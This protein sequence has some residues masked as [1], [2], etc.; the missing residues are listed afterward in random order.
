MNGDGDAAG[1]DSF[2]A[3]WAASDRAD[4]EGCEAA[5]ARFLEIG[6]P[7]PVRLGAQEV[8]SRLPGYVPED[9]DALFH[10]GD[11]DRTRRAIRAFPRLRRFLDP[12]E[13]AR[14]HEN[15]LAAAVREEVGAD[16]TS[17]ADVKHP[18]RALAWF[19]TGFLILHGRAFGDGPE[20]W[21][22]ND[23]T[24]RD[25]FARK[26]RAEALFNLGRL[27]ERW[28]AS[29]R[30][31]WQK[32]RDAAEER[33]DALAREWREIV[34]TV[35]RH[36]GPNVGEGEALRAAADELRMPFGAVRNVWYRRRPR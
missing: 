22:T 7:D 4:A 25:A 33:R 12:A 17:L 6:R 26:A 9:L 16:R 19:V 21:G 20:I 28:A 5:L 10:H 32:A 2:R 27:F 29:G 30:T 34:E 1:A 35:E 36:R 24:E 15:D 14:T 8:E 3:A 11:L 13:V 18:R 31:Q 23:P